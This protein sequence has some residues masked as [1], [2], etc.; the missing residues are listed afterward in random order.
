MHEARHEFKGV[1]AAIITPYDS[2]G[3]INED[4]YRKIV[5]FNIDAGI[6]GFWVA[7][8]TG[9][10]V[11]L[12]DDERI[13]LGQ[14]TVEQA[15]G[16]A[17]TI[18][19]AGALTTRSAA[20]IAE[21]GSK[22]GADAI[23]CVPPFFYGPSDAA[24]VEHYKTVAAA[25]DLPFFLYNLPSCTGFEITP[26]RAEK[27]AEAVPQLAG[28]K[29]SVW[30]QNNFQSFIDMDMAAFIGISSMLLPTLTLGGVGTIDGFP[31]VFPEVFVEIYNAYQSGDLKRA[32]AAQKKANSF[33]RL[34]FPGPFH[35]AF[36]SAF[37]T[38]M[39]ERLGIDCGGARRPLM[40]LTPEQRQDLLNRTRK[41][42]LL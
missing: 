11:L 33:N 5:N 10:S 3:N 35:V 32:E 20:R 18:L 41:L 15:Q 17:K 16:R 39:R 6:D 2:E 24:M 34:V 30:D 12:D 28:L 22:A 14:I 37:K 9:E 36:H 38:V 1:I 25:A 29:H 42:G 26:S 4:A 27:V 31:N 21:A 13:R 7:G 19:H 40:D 8:G 23:A